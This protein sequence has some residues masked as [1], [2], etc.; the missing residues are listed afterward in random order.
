MRVTH[1]LALVDKI[2]QMLADRFD[3]GEISIFLKTFK[4]PLPT[5]TNW[6]TSNLEY[7]KSALHPMGPEVIIAIA[8][9]LEIELPRGQAASAVPPTIWQGT[10]KFRLFISH[11]AKDKD[12]AM[13]LRTCL[14]PYAVS[15]FVAHEDISPTEDWQREI[16]RALHAM[17]AFLAIHTVGFKQS[18]WTQQEIGFAVGRGTKI[19]SFKMGEDPTGFISIRQA[20]PRQNR[21]AEEVARE[22]DGLLGADQ[23]TAAKLLAAKKANRVVAV[24]D[25]D[26]PF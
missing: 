2:G 16:E 8:E 11:I 21:K 3:F 6:N 22:I 26:I 17:D 14:A 25:D 5:G 10:N 18:I 24:F 12:K 13:R 23:A 4:V 1:K 20:L 7:A 15:G 9:E 19:I